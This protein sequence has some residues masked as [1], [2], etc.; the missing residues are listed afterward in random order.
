M[1]PSFDEL[2]Q[3]IAHTLRVP[4]EALDALKA[5]APAV[6]DAIRPLAERLRVG[7]WLSPAEDAQLFYGLHALACAQHGSA[8]GLWFD[9]LSDPDEATLEGL[10][11]DGATFA[12]T[13]ITMGLAAGQGAAFEPAALA[14]L[15][16]DRAI[17]SDA[18]WSLFEVLARFMAEGRFPRAAYIALVDGVASWAQEDEGNAW[19]A[20]NAITLAGLEERRELLLALYGT[21]AF[22]H[23]HEVDKAHALERLAAAAAAGGD[24]AR[25]DTVGIKAFTDPGAA[26]H[27]MTAII[28]SQEPDPGAESALG[29][30]EVRTLDQLLQ[31][32]DNPPETMRFEEL[33]GFLHALVIGPD[34]VMPSEYLPVVWD[35]GPVFEDMAEAQAIMALMQRHWNAIA[36]RRGAGGGFAPYLE[37]HE[38]MEPG[39]PWARGFLKGVMLRAEAWAQMDEDEELVLAMASISDLFEGDELDEVDRSFILHDLPTSLEVLSAYWLSQMRRPSRSALRRPQTPAWAADRPEPV[40]AQK[41]GRNERCPCGSGKKWKKCCG[42]GPAGRGGGEVPLT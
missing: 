17:G 8:W 38:G 23:F 11:G 21:P 26:L 2:M 41:I 36:A 37:R 5:H 1:T 29:W 32:P 7:A 30:R 20:E 12:I 33:D 25:F 31:R 19:A 40:R 3:D 16:A 9:L 24:L 6:L 14:L 22:T 39:A 13:R 35:D 28:D 27:W 34:I 10:F 18:R 4:A 42:A 15:I